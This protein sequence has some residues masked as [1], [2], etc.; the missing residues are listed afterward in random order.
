MSET[1]WIQLDLLYKDLY[2][3]NRNNNYVQYRISNF[4]MYI[5]F[6]LIN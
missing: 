3:G 6:K 1:L 5:N 4:K 2:L